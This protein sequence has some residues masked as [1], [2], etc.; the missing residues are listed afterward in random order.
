MSNTKGPE[1]TIFSEFERT[2]SVGDGHHMF[3]FLGG[4]T[5]VSFKKGWEKFAAGDGQEVTPGFPARNEH[6]LDWIAVLSAVSRAKGAFRMAELGAGWAPWLAS[7]FLACQQKRIP[8][9]KIEMVGVEADPKHFEWMQQH[10]E[11][12]GMTGDSFKALEGAISAEEGVLRFPDIEEDQK[13]VDYGASVRVGKGLEKF[14]E[15]KAISMESI[16]AE[17]SGSI[18][19]VHMDIQGEEYE[20]LDASIDTVNTHVKSIMVGTHISNDRHDG[21][22]DFFYSQDCWDPYMIYPRNEK[23]HTEYGEIQLADGFQYWVNKNL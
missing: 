6:Y 1:H 10:F 7:A 9:K 2:K 8:E 4:A 19:F 5:N 18:D 13:S 3:D 17:F 21:L 23:V 20:V 12:N 16:I 11:R 22:I 14:I 15:V